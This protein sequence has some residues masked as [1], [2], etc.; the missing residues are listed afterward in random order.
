MAKEW[1]K[2]PVEP[3]KKP[4]LGKEDVGKEGG[5]IGKRG[6]APEVEMPEKKKEKDLGEPA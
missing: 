3:T 4:D 6:G 2:K 5:E 1:E